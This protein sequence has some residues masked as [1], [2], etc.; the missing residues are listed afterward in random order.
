VLVAEEPASSCFP[1]SGEFMRQQAQ[2]PKIRKGRSVIPLQKS[3]PWSRRVLCAARDTWGRKVLA[4]E[5]RQKIK[6]LIAA[7]YSIRSIA[8]TLDISTRTVMKYNS[9]KPHGYLEE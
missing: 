2:C 4:G 3:L 1:T 7:K 5:L 9:I 8:K 6:D